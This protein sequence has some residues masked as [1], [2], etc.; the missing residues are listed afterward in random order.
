MWPQ[1]VLMRRPNKVMIEINGYK[2]SR[3]YVGNIAVI[4]EARPFTYWF[5][6]KFTFRDA[7]LL[8]IV[9]LCIEPLQ[10]HLNQSISNN[11]L[12]HLVTK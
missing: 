11:I 12:F 9:V 7:Y 4:L 5:G 6:L 1:I 3:H 10:P 8:F 2:I